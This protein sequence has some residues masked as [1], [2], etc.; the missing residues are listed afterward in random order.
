MTDMEIKAVIFDLG[1]VV[2]ES[3]MD[4]FVKFETRL[5]LPP[6]TLNRHIVNSGPD[7]AW[8]GLEK[9]RLSQAQFIDAF[10]RELSQAGLPVSTAELMAQITEHAAVRPVMVEAIR[11]LRALGYKVAALTNN[12]LPDEDGRGGM[13]DFKAEFDVFVESSKSGLQKPDPRIY[14]LACRELDLTPQEAVFLDD[15]GRNLKTARELG[16]T[17]IKV[18][19]AQTALEELQG[20][21]G[22][23]LPEPQR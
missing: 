10:D 9:G 19:D 21:L 20:I 17:T 14:E 11:T 4:V 5:G 6:N 22:V 13:D 7:G 2:F 8:A 3:P 23:R 12:W 1:G 16:M 15:I 18:G